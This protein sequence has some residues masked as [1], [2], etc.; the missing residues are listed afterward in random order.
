MNTPIQPRA[1]TALSIEQRFEK[2]RTYPRPQPP[3]FSSAEGERQ[4]RKETLAAA[5]RIFGKLGYDEGVMGHISARDP[6]NPQHFWINPFGLSFN[7]I[8]AGDLQRV[9]LDGDLIEG[10]GCPHPGGIPLHSAILTLRPDIVSVAHTHSLY[11]RTWSTT[12]RLLP[13]ASAESAVFYGKH[14]LYDSHAHGEG[15]NLVNA[16][17]TNRA[18]LMKNHGLL[19]VGQTVDEA[20]YLFISLEK[21]CQSQIAAESIGSAQTME[22]EHARRGAE[23]FQAYNGWL[24]FQPLYQS[25][26]KEQPD[27]LQAANRP[28]GS[29]S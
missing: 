27:L 9:S 24:N 7:L 2:A 12:G 20:A 23:R 11:G 8:T 26:V 19:T 16:L 28:H 13:A 15:D 14:A 22:E 4:H 10:H 29:H 21:I 18:L 3:V 17:G 1:N 25:I 5:F 6:E